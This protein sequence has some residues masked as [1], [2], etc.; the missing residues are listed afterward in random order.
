M[1]VC[2]CW[3]EVLPPGC[4]I[5][6]A[7]DIADIGS[8][9][10]CC[11][12]RNKVSALWVFFLNCLGSL[13]RNKMPA[14][15][16]PYSFQL[17]IQHLEVPIYLPCRAII[18]EATTPPHKCGGGGGA[19]VRFAVAS[20]ASGCSAGVSASGVAEQTSDPFERILHYTV[21]QPPQGHHPL[22][23]YPLMICVLGELLPAWLR[24]CGSWCWLHNL[25]GFLN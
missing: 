25:F 2:V 16:M 14:R 3:Q 13:T 5:Q 24:C 18:Q 6:S 23:N 15:A 21:A 4:V 1:C 19:P 12:N 10:S 20:G 17:K 22:S 11:K 8:R 7:K 9:R